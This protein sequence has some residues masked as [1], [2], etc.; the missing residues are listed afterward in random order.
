MSEQFEFD[1]EHE[2]T[3]EELEAMGE[4]KLF[5]RYEKKHGRSIVARGWSTGRIIEGILRSQDEE[6]SEVHTEDS[7]GDREDLRAPYRR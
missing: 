2:P 5:E 6:E 4:K 1:Y 3:R 7:E